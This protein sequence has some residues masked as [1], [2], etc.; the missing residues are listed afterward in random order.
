MI[1]VLT[2][3]NYPAHPG[4]V[5][6]RVDNFIQRINPYPVYYKIGAFLILIG[7]QANFADP[8]DGDLSAG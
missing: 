5:V 3:C 8:L 1:N 6:R 7:Q 4:L 2:F